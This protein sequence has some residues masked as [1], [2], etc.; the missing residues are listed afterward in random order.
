MAGYFHIIPH[1]EELTIETPT[2]TYE[3]MSTEA[4][5]KVV[6]RW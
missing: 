2:D 6:K 5:F 4:L 1:P 3:P